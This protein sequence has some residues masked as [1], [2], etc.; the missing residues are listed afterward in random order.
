MREPEPELI[1]SSLSRKFT[2]GKVAVQVNIFRLEN[3]TEWT[4]EVV[5]SEGTSTVWDIPFKNDADA[6]AEFERVVV[7]EGM[8]AFDGVSSPE[9]SNVIPFRR[10][11]YPQSAKTTA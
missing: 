4:L 8:V 7:E 2:K 9:A 1:S 10:P 5:N 6:F 11:R 3:E